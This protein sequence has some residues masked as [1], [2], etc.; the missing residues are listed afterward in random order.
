MAIPGILTRAHRGRVAH[1]EDRG[2]PAPWGSA[3]TRSR[4]HRGVQARKT[5]TRLREMVEIR[6]SRRGIYRILSARRLCLVPLGGV[7]GIRRQDARPARTRR[8]GRVR[9]CL[10]RS[11]RVRRVCLRGAGRSSMRFQGF[12]YRAHD[13]RWSWLAVSGEGA[14]FNEGR[15]DVCWR[16]GDRRPSRIELIDDDH[17]LTPAS[18]PPLETS[19]TPPPEAP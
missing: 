13:P 3:G 6:P 14:R 1:G 7:A 19:R 4:A 15:F 12:V 8:R 5:Q 9:A 10:P 17:R 18:R 16:W 11:D 2:Q